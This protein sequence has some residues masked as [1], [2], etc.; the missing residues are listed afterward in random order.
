[1]GMVAFVVIPFVESIGR[2]RHYERH[3]AVF[4]ALFTMLR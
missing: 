3:G 1:M 4:A 2:L